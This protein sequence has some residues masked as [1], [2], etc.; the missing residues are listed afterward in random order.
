MNIHPFRYEHSRAEAL[1]ILCRIFCKDQK[2]QQFVRP[3]LDNFYSVIKR[4]LVHGDL[5]SLISIIMNTQNLY[6]HELVGSYVL[7]QDFI[8][9]FFRILPIVPVL[10]SAL[11]SSHLCVPPD[12]LRKT[13]YQRIASIMS[14]SNQI[15]DSSFPPDEE[16]VLKNHPVLSNAAIVTIQKIIYDIYTRHN[17]ERGVLEENR[18]W[19]KHLFTL[20]V[21]CLVTEMNPN[22]CR[23]LLHVVACFTIHESVITPGIIDLVLKLI[24]EKV[25]DIDSC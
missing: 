6:V 12:I 17:A 10:P 24:Q 19:G 14:L 22:N 3:Y 15:R 7:V 9:A 4:G 21:V 8:V 11:E 13:C 1:A 25:N 5:L 18:S 20:L 16:P 23:Y 2:G